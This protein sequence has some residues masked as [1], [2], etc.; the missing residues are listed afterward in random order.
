[1][2][3]LLIV[4][5]ENDK[6]FVEALIDHININ[7]LEVSNGVICDIDDYECLD[8]LSSKK[9]VYVL[10]AVKSKAKKDN[11]SNLGILIDL[12]EKTV[13]E[14]LE[15]VNNSIKEVFPS[16]NIISKENDFTVFQIDKFQNINIA[17]YFTKVDGAGELETI[18]KEIKSLESPY[19]DCLSSWQDCLINNGIRDGNGLKKKDFDKFWIQVYIR[20]DACSR[21]EQKQA[22]R[23]CSTHVSMRKAIWNFE[24]ECLIE[25]KC[26]LRLI[27]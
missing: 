24:H 11:I 17:V 3:N 21:R 8:G 2:K 16:E 6:Y 23:K 7:S 1:M 13:E 27:S 4:E 10:R 14:R 5:S 9:L 12:D 20:Y 15:L 18:L 19:A 25:L 22:G 26:F